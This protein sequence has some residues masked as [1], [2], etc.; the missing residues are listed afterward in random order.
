MKNEINVPNSMSAARILLTPIL[1]LLIIYSN[2][3]NYP[4]LI[5]LYFLSIW[6]D[7]FD[8]YFARKLGQETELG[9]ILDPLADKLLILFTMVALL[10]KT[11]FPLWFALV[12]ISRDILILLAS[13]VMLKGRHTVKGSIL[14]G[15]ITFAG[16]GVLLLI[17]IIDLHP[18]L[19]LEILKRFFLVLSFSYLLWSW[20]EYYIIYKRFAKADGVRTP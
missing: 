19:N 12:I 10:I 4:W 8:G 3:G 15:K 14:T 5:G 13:F 11:D 17:Y 7:F 20:I 1:F 6:L 16:L 2:P 9:K 18:G